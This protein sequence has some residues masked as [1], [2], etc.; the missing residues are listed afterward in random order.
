MATRSRSTMRGGWAAEFVLLLAASTCSVLLEITHA[1]SAGA[2]CTQRE[3]DTL[4]AFKRGIKSGPAGV[5]ASWRRGAHEHGGCCCQWRGFSCSN[6]TGHVLELRL[7]NGDLYDG[8]ALVGQISRSLLSLEQLEYLD[9]GMNSLEGSSGRIPEFLGSFK[10]L[11]HLNLS[12]IP[13]SGRVPPQLGNLSKLQYLDISGSQGTFSLDISWLMHLKFLL[14]LNLKTV[15]LS[16]TTDWPHVVNMIPSLKFLDLSDCLLA[17]ANQLI[18]HRNRTN[19]EWLDLSGNYFHHQI[20][21]SWFWN[22]T[23]LKYLNLQF[24]S[25]HG[26]L[27]DALGR[28]IPLQYI[29]LSGNTIDMP[30]VDLKNLCSLRVIHLESCFSYGSIEEL[31]ERFPQCSPNNLQQLHL[32]SNQLTGILPSSMG[33]PSYCGF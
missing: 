17:S 7:R 21:A 33:Q 32:Q 26:R 24:T 11:K 13:F 28:M 2:N 16:T 30:M 29:D 22:L 10:N 9:L 4:L 14:H 6:W 20:A 8:Y 27:P 3:M 5:L 1:H 15:N 18:P 19:L 23:S 31:M 25:M 12:G